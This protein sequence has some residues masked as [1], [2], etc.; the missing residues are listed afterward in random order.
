MG[1]LY[2]DRS[3]LKLVVFDFDCTLTTFHVFASL[4]GCAINQGNLKLE[5]QPPYARSERG[6]MTRLHALDADATWGP[7]GFAIKAFGGPSRLAQLHRLFTELHSHNVECV[8]SSY[9][10]EG[11][12]RQC[13]KQVNL[14][15][16]FSDVVANTG[17]SM[18]S[19]EYD[20]SL[21]YSADMPR[22]QR[23]QPFNKIEHLRT[24]MVDK[25]LNAYQ[26]AFIDDDS[27]TVGSVQSICR[28]I[29]VASGIGIQDREVQLLRSMLQ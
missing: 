17:S 4:A 25:Q 28:T 24:A 29:H 20:F 8:I 10:M 6:Q 21:M 11:S 13:L 27:S 19:T 7:G 26:V 18:G 16:Y 3:S 15:Q 22:S 2:K 5:V 1:S 12:I 14:S 9:G 23:S